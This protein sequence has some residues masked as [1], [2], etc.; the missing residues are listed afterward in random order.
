MTDY[1]TTLPCPL[2]S[3]GASTSAKA[4]TRIDFDYRSRIMNVPKKLQSFTVAI[5][6]NE[7][8]LDIFNIFYE[9]VLTSDFAIRADWE[10]HANRNFEKVFKLSSTPT[11]KSHGALQYN[12]TFNVEV[13]W[14]GSL[15]S[16]PLYPY[17]A[18]H[19]SKYL[20][21]SGV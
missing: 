16:N 11:V 17:I 12:I 1:P 13:L 5:N 7:A 8:E 2:L 9:A 20:Y 19:P 18:L 6:C 4:S 14:F 15:Y 10:V 21:P 3:S